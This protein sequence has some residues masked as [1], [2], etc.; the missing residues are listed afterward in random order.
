MRDHISLY[1]PHIYTLRLKNEMHLKNEKTK[2]RSVLAKKRNE[3][4]ILTCWILIYVSVSVRLRCSIVVDVVVNDVVDDG[5]AT[6]RFSKN[7]RWKEER[8]VW[9]KRER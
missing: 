5:F 6:A 8:G 7:G 1:Y 2:I 9:G 4:P 3:T